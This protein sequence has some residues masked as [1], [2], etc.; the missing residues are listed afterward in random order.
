MEWKLGI[1]GYLANL[2]RAK[3]QLGYIPALLL[4]DADSRKGRENKLASINRSCHHRM[5]IR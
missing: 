4:G 5:L 3:Q 2:W 1:T